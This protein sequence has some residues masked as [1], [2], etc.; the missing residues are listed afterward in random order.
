[1]VLPKPLSLMH[2]M[3]PLPMLFT[4]IKFVMKEKVNIMTFYTLIINIKNL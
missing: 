1:M 3:I 2:K 4:M